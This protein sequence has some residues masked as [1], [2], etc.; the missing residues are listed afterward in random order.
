L[1][2]GHGD[3]GVGQGRTADL[4]EVIQLDHQALA[5]VVKIGNFVKRLPLSPLGALA[6]TCVHQGQVMGLARY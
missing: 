3:A 2:L 6:I 4:R 5:H 1:S